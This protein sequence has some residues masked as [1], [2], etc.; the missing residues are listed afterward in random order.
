M[1][2]HCKQSQ[3]VHSWSINTSLDQ[4]MTC[5]GCLLSVCPALTVLV[6]DTTHRRHKICHIHSSFYLSHEHDECNPHAAGRA[7][8]SPVPRAGQ[9]AG[10]PRT[11]AA[12]GRRS[13]RAHPAERGVCCRTGAAAA[14][15]SAPTDT[16]AAAPGCCGCSRHRTGSC[17]IM[18]LK[19]NDLQ[20]AEDAMDE[21]Q[22]RS[23]HCL[24]GKHMLHDALLLHL[25]TSKEHH[26]VMFLQ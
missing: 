2:M 3:H 7:G 15:R 16:L 12:A 21:R 17:L 10:C 18:L 8:Q 19:A 4:I 1:P 14:D 9:S 6:S 23:Q 5:A 13:L 11:L 25:Q 22:Q 20:T 26:Q 24:S